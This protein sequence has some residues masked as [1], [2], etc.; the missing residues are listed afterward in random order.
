MSIP[1]LPYRPGGGRLWSRIGPASGMLFVFL[2]LAGFI[3]HGYPAIRP[4]DGQLQEWIT[5]TDLNRF[6]IGV[7]IEALGTLCLLPFVAWLYTSLRSITGYRPWTAVLALAAGA[8]Y[9]VLVLPI[10]ESWVGILEQGK[11]G[12]DVRVSQTLVST[13]QAWFLMSNMLLGLFLIAAGL[14]ILQTR[15]IGRWAGWAAIAIG[16]LG[17]LPGVGTLASFAILPWLL[18]MGAYYSIRPLDSNPEAAAHQVQP[19]VT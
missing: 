7:Y 2:V 12:L 16:A 11:Q 3:V 6:T 5:V 1:D 8:G 15:A 10:N 4:S 19:S 17:M 18:G 13:S 14:A 9:V